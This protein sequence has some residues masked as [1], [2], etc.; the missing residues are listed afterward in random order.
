MAPNAPQQYLTWVHEL[1]PYLEQKTMRSQIEAILMGPTPEVRLIAGKLKIVVCPSDELDA[2]ISPV[3]LL[4]YSQLSYAVN[5]GLTD[6]YFAAA[7]AV[8]GY[9]WPQ[10]GLFDN[11]LKGSSATEIHKIFQSTLQGIT[12][13]SSNT[14]LIAENSDAEEWNDGSHEFLVG[15]VW[16]EN[17]AQ[18]L[19]KYPSGLNPPHVKPGTFAE[20][21]ASGVNLTP[22]AR[23]LSQHPTGFMVVFADGH[24]KFISESI[25]YDVYARLMTSDGARYMPAGVNEVPPSATTLNIRHLQNIAVTDGSY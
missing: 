21:A 23:P 5:S 8:S 13:G 18:S 14:I 9:D 16:T 10:N 1:L 4:P 6:N 20:M 2:N 24:S 3:S 22:Y 11:R 25:A 17:G 15:I 19:N 7:P 12:D